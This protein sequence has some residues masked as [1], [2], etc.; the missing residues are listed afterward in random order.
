VG[1]ILLEQHAKQSISRDR[2]NQKAARQAN[3]KH[4]SQDMSQNRAQEIEHIS[5]EPIT[6]AGNRKLAQYQKGPRVCWDADLGPY[7]E[8]AN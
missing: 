2:N 8:V 1:K 3:P 7:G 6:L 4:P 5:L